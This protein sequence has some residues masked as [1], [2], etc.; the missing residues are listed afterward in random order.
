VTYSQQLEDDGPEI[1]FEHEPYGDIL[2]AKVAD[3][4]V[5][6]Y[7]VSDDGCGVNP[8]KDWD[9]NGELITSRQGVIT[10]GDVCTH[11][12]LEELGGRFHDGSKNLELDGIYERTTAKY[13]ELIAASER[14]RTW[15]VELRLQLDCDPLADVVDELSGGYNLI[16]W[17]D[18]DRECFGE[19]PE[20][21]E[22]AEQ[23]WDELYDEGKIG[24]YLAV[25]VKYCDNNHGPGTTT[26]STT[27]VDNAN[28]VW[29]PSKCE[30]DNMNFT[31]CTTYAEKL[32]V[33]DKYA[34]S[35]LDVYE[36]WCNGEVFGCVVQTHEEDG[37]LLNDA[38]CWGFIG[39]EYAGQS[40]KDDFFNY[41]CKR[42][43]AEYDEAVRTGSG[44][45]Q[46]MTL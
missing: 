6:A 5:V 28:A 41:T 11:L 2:Q 35:C 46:E 25:P 15:F 16:E 29:I 38:S 31:D 7:L 37:E 45:Q 36:Q 27:S 17:D 1:D 32:A 4:Y 22:L 43:Q 30:L 24:T 20:Y 40:L 34:T 18:N 23:A 26:I 33:A 3:K 12:G 14:L 19:L 42:V 13:K 9:G 10:D 39:Y 21:Q 8:L 44:C